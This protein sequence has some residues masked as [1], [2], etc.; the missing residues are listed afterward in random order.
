MIIGLEDMEATYGDLNISVINLKI[1][2][3]KIYKKWS[4]LINISN[5]TSDLYFVKPF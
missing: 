5:I 1:S 4:K 3:L 2:K